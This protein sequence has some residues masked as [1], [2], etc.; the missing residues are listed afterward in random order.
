MRMRAEQRGAPMWTRRM[1]IRRSLMKTILTACFV[2]ATFLGASVAHSD[3]LPEPLA[4]IALENR[5]AIELE[6]GKLAGEGAVRLLSEAR[7]ADIFLFGEN[8]GIAQVAGISR[9][10]YIELSAPTPRLLVTEVSPAAATEIETMF[11]DGTLQDFIARG[12]NVH[13]IPFFTV[14]EEYPLLESVFEL[15]PIDAPA[16]W[17]L[18][19]EFMGGAP[20]VLQ[21]LE[22][23]ARTEAERKAVASARR[24][25]LLNPFMVGMGS[26]KTLVNL[27]D[28][29]AASETVEA[30]RLTD[31]LL[32]SHKI[33]SEQM[34]GDARWSNE[35]REALMEEN[36]LTYLA[37]TPE[38]GPMFFKFGGTHIFNGKGLTVE[39]PLGKRVAEW[40]AER[41]MSVLNLMV[42][43][44]GGETLGFLFGRSKP[45]DTLF[46][47]K[48]DAFQHL[49]LEDDMTLFDLR[50]LRG[51]A[52]LDEISPRLQ[53]L[54]NGY[55]YFIIVPGA[56]PSSF[57]PGSLVTYR[58]GGIALAILLTLLSGVL[59]LGVKFFRRRRVRKTTAFA[60]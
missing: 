22:K 26:G 34:G 56:R 39:V 21:R 27:R 1:A 23:L 41:D 46:T 2:A 55:D 57:M 9:A 53:R 31:Q 15:I 45:C 51:H 44:S 35:R 12:I 38:P 6:G 43:C 8:H 14:V 40:A 18:D 60:G 11:R 7:E 5:F 4:E 28:A 10:I 37:K 58:Y 48:A 20:I 19:Q 54:I 33:Y 13:A 59:F 47:G 36:F 17:G 32:L 16:I 30:R 24:A 52:G 25:S 29:F 3:P 49:L 50:P 42:D